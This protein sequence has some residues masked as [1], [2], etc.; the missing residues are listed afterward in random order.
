MTE[1]SKEYPLSF[2]FGVEGKEG[3]CAP[4]IPKDI[5][6]EVDIYY[7]NRHT[8]FQKTLFMKMEKLLSKIL[9][10]SYLTLRIQI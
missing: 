2:T 5:V 9:R 8:F 4:L 7:I 3:S 1:E 6:E 10:K